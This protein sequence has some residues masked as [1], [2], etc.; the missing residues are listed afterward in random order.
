MIGLI[1]ATS[2]NGVIGITDDNGNG[3]LPFHYPDDMRY[4]RETTR[5][6]IVI[7]GR[8]T[9]ESIGKPLPKRENIIISSS[10]LEIPGARCYASVRTAMH[11]ES[12]KLS[13]SQR[14]IWFI[15]GARIYEE[16]MLYADE[17]H[18][19]ITPDHIHEKE[20]IRFPWIN[21]LLFEVKISMS[22]SDP[23]SDK[24]L[25]TIYQRKKMPYAYDRAIS[26]MK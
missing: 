24:L 5:N 3:K 25:C 13:R 1:A 22:I 9:F 11:D 10:L 6:S 12:I 4:F 8:R 19:T 20:M 26:D 14:N 17:I 15:G 21:P 23:P 16:G 18:L 7:M 2:M